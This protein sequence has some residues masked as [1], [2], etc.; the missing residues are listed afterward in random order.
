MTKQKR[1]RQ[2]KRK[3]TPI[4]ISNEPP[5]STIQPANLIADNVSRNVIK[6]SCSKV[7]RNKNAATTLQNAI[8]T[9]KAKR[10]VMKQRQIVDEAKLK[11]MEEK[12]D[13]ERQ[14]KTK[15]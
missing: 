9:R 12:L 4:T 15:L 2:N 7:E 13:K 10:D 8:R 3:A 1:F 14:Q 5:T 6:N 11:Q